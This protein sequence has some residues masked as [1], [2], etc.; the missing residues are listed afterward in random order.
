MLPAYVNRPFNMTL[1]L[2]RVHED[3]GV[4]LWLAV[5]RVVKLLRSLTVYNLVTQTYREVFRIQP[6][7]VVQMLHA[8]LINSMEAHHPSGSMLS[9]VL[10]SSEVTCAVE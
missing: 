10:R 5:L 6:L 9:T 7:P 1:M 8:V 2:N 4:E 3:F